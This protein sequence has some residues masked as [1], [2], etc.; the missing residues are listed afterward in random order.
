MR[1]I[2]EKKTGKLK[3]PTSA[4]HRVVMNTGILYAKMGITMFISLYTTR[5]ILNSLGASDFGIFSVVGG[6]IGMLGFLN[7]AM[8]GATQRFMSYAEG[9]GDKEKQ[10]SIFNVS[11]I[12]HVLLAGIVGVVLFTAG[13]FFFSGILNIPPERMDAA[14]LVYYFMIV[15]TMITVLTA[16]YDAVLNAHE[17]M[18]YFAVVGIIESV[19]KLGVAF[20][21]VYT[22]TDKLIVY[23]A[24]MTGI[25]LLV[26]II[27]RVYCHKKYEECV[28]SPKVYYD[29]DLMQEMTGFAGWNFLTSASSMIGQY[30]LGVVLNH[31]F[32]TLL[33]AAQGVA[34]Q[35]S[36]Q[37][38][39]FSNTMMKALNPIIVKKE[40]GGERF[41][42]HRATFA[43]AKYSFLLLTFFAIPF[44]IET[45]YILKLW[46]K[47]NIP[48]SAIIFCRLHVALFLLEQL[49]L[50]IGNF[51]QAQGNIKN[52]SKIKSI[53]YLMPIILTI[54][55]FSCG[56]PAYMM[57]VAW[58]VCWC[59][60]GG[61]VTLYYAHRN[62]GMSYRHYITS[63]LS[64]SLILF[65]IVFLTGC[66]PNILMAE[67]FVRLVIVF[68][69]SFAAYMFTI[70]HISINKAEKEIFKGIYRKL[71]TSYF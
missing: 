32:G 22:L 41:L 21:V 47:N 53:F 66:F 71:K 51:I 6:V 44:I 60:L 34:N 29:K 37:L 14:R 50:P 28:F 4:A 40:G 68:L 38:M 11:I 3:Q 57:Y 27:M 2:F 30:G 10:K 23:G 64:P 45:P 58:M 36:G 61:L 31:F 25:S 1:L 35:L 13:Y 24:L 42:A 55:L 49:T 52:Y 33:N 63:V 39:A 18:L 65:I 15:S 19:L 59:I 12:L 9:A 7:A 69:L 62:G 67:S 20:V 16:P 56:F 46:L 8:A 48:V 43:G 17:N 54:G 26:M 5:L 70:W